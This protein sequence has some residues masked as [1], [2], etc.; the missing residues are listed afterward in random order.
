MVATATA[1][2]E[3]L[4]VAQSLKC[5]PKFIQPEDSS[6]SSKETSNDTYAEPDQSIP[7]N[8]ILAL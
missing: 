3:K 8:P 5:F 4:P 6:P 2:V 1:F 7:H